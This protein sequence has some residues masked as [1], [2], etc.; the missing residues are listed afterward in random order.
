MSFVFCCYPEYVK[1]FLEIEPGLAR[2]INDILRFEDY[3]EDEIC[4]ILLIKAN[5]KGYIISDECKACILDELRKLIDAR[6]AQNG[7]T[8]EKLLREIEVSMGLRIN[9]DLGNVQALPFTSE[10]ERALFTIDI[11]D[12][13]QAANRLMQSEEARIG[14]STHETIL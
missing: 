1:E 2:R 4:S 6:A 9:A 8:A 11:S 13:I 14:V 5:K 3:N 7:G 10:N 12:I